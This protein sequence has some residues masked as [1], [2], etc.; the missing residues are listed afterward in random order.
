MTIF[1]K[2]IPNLLIGERLVSLRE[3]N[4]LGL[5][6]FYSLVDGKFDFIR[7]AVMVSVSLSEYVLPGQRPIQ[8]ERELLV[9]PL[10]LFLSG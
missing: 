8:F 10:N 1:L 7:V 5:D 9:M 3:L 2:I 4:E 6:L